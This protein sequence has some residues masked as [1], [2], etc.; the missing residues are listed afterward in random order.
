VTLPVR[1]VRRQLTAE[2]IPT[3]PDPRI[4]RVIRSTVP[5]GGA[6]ETVRGT[7]AVGIGYTDFVVQVLHRAGYD[8]EIVQAP[9][10]RRARQ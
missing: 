6:E 4:A 1:I 2:V 8:V 9:Q 5:R 3:S 10:P 7:W